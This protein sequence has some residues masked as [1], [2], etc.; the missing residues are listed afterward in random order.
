MLPGVVAGSPQSDKGAQLNKIVILGSTGSIGRQAIDI[1]ARYPQEFQIVGLAAH[2]DIDTLMAQADLTK[3]EFICVVNE[4]AASRLREDRLPGQEQPTLLV[5]KE[6]LQVAATWETADT[7][8]NAIVGGAGLASTLA[9]LKAGKRLALANK[10]SLV[11]GGGLVKEALKRSS[12]SLVPVDSEHNAIWQC[13]VGEDRNE[14]AKLILTAS[15]GPFWG[16]VATELDSVTA[17]EALAH[18]RWQMGQRISIDSATLL[19]KGLEVIEAHELFD[20]SYDHIDVVIH[21]QSIIHS[22]VEFIDGSFKAQLGPTDMR[23]PILYALSWPRRLEPR[24]PAFD[25]T[26]VGD[27]TLSKIEPGQAPCFDLALAAGRSG[28]SYPTVLNAADE[29][30]VSAFLSGRIRFNDIGDT[31]ARVLETHKPSDINSVDDFT[32]VDHW[33]K[34]TTTTFLER[35][36]QA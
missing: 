12:G 7:I 15:G 3:P 28:R 1:I 32:T 23:L 30:A 22:M 35:G 19:N 27:L 8:L 26:Q 34:E 11:A 36:V 33:A 14:V 10:E 4:S 5:G 24:L 9:G 25:I 31:I 21:P 2:S 16:R 20:F 13:L 17:A 6:G 18:P 29:I